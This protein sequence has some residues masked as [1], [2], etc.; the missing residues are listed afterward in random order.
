MRAV[1]HMS[2][3]MALMVI[4]AGQ[5]FA[6]SYSLVRVGRAAAPSGVAE[7]VSFDSVNRRLYTTNAGGVEYFKV[8][9]GG[10]LAHKGAIDMT[11][12]FPLVSSV[13][14]VSIDPLGRGFGAASVIPD[15][16]DTS[17]GAIVIFDTTTNAILKTL[18]IGYNPDSVSFTPDGQ[19]IVIADEGEPNTLDPD[20]S[21]SVVDVS[22]IGSAADISGLA[23]S[24]VGTFDFRAPNLGAGVTLDN[25]RINPANA[26]N[27]AADVEPEYVAADNDGVWVSLQENNALARFDFDSMQWSTIHSLGGIDQTI[28]AS[29]RDGGIFIDDVVHGLFMPDGI[30]SYEVGGTRFVVSANEGDARDDEEVRFKDANI[31][32]DVLAELDALY[33]GN[34][35]ADAA[36]G[37]LTLSMIDGD[38]DGDGDIDVPTMYG[39]RSFTIWNSETGEMVFDSGSDFETITAATLP[40]SFNSEGTAAT[41]DGRSDNK[42]PEPEGVV[43][44]SIGDRTF[45]FVGL[46]RVGGVMMYDVSDPESAFFVD[47]I[48]TATEANGG[49][50]PEGLDFFEMDGRYFLAVSY[51]VSG[52]VEIFR[53]LPAPGG[54][55]LAALGGLAALRRRR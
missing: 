7:I 45:A 32:P 17:V 5:A 54:V 12:V 3:A 14:S 4:G 53:I 33:G 16:N 30:A 22:G 18:S 43:I 47:Y 24:D 2:C 13:A 1:S 39:S 19:R 21:L 51:E 42:G 44:G 29:D 9:Q 10:M 40:A 31:D 34:A 6:G 37:R 11:A 49:L 46:E 41:F 27:R 55:A 26:M 8:G 36:L 23:Q 15:P 38:T 35:R 25:L 28:D 52:S 20:G 50:S 48:N